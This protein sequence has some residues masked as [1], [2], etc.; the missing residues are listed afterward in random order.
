MPPETNKTEILLVGSYTDPPATGSGVSVLEFNP[1]DGRLTP[2]AALGGMIN[3]S[4]LHPVGNR[5]Y[6]ACEAASG[7]AGLAT[8]ELEP[9]P[10]IRHIEPVD[11][12]LPCHL[13]STQRW[14]AAACYGSGNVVIHAIDAAG[15]ARLQAAAFQHRGSGPHPT[16]QAGP[17]AHA[18]C[19]SPDRRWLLVPDL[20]S[21]RIWC[22]R[23][24]D[25]TGQLGPDPLHW[26]APPGSGP[27]H[28]GFSADGRSAVLLTELSR[29]VISLSWN[30]GVLHTV[31]SIDLDGPGTAAALRW[32]PTG[33]MLAVSIRTSDAI[34]LLDFDP[35]TGKLALLHQAPCGGAKPR[36]CTFSPCGNWLLTANQDGNT[37]A[38][39][40]L[41][42]QRRR[43]VD[44]G[45]R[46]ATGAP[47][48]LQFIKTPA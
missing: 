1:A 25:A 10:R 47:A 15:D 28:V 2:Q 36:D 44:T 9:H 31:D 16:R 34:A 40:A 14:I 23:F 29:S 32:H 30:D 7:R 27:R 45:L 48:S 19:F 39:L 8:I 4:W 35:A 37:I 6:A 24:D 13:A 21:D 3:P 12:D 20:G 43:L 22:H 11:G 26:Q 18:A 42:A 33:T 38:V 17:H 5:L 41:D 46:H